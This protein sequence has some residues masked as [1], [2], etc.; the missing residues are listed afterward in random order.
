MLSIL[1]MYLGN[2]CHYATAM[3]TRILPIPYMIY[4]RTLVHH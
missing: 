3:N 4:Y 1:D 2:K